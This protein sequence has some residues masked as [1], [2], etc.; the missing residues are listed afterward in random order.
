MRSG[1]LS[2]LFKP[3]SDHYLTTPCYINK[4]NSLPSSL[5][6]L[7]SNR[8][9]IRSLRRQ[10]ENAYES[11]QI[12]QNLFGHQS[13]RYYCILRVKTHINCSRILML[14]VCCGVG[15][16]RDVSIHLSTSWQSLRQL[17]HY[18]R[19]YNSKDTCHVDPIPKVRNGALLFLCFNL[20]FW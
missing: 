17:Y 18:G 10:S 12:H 2:N 14:Q 7:E 20:S 19:Y 16:F 4:K 9:T 15:R 3:W 6:D 13:T 1:V 8:L 11:F 5:R